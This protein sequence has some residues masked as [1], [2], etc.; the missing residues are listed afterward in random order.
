MPGVGSEQIMQ[1]G[2]T[3]A[4]QPYDKERRADFLACDVGI[5]LPVPLH[6]QTRAQRLQNIRSKGDLS[7]KIKPCLALTGLEQARERFKKVALAEIIK[8]AA[9]LGSLDQVSRKRS[10]KW[11]SCFFQQCAES[12]EEPNRQERTDLLESSSGAVHSIKHP[13]VPAVAFDSL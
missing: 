2:S 7:D 12:I 5:E 6:Q 4:R 8:T 13:I 11:N 10:G 1:Q 3:A 9:S